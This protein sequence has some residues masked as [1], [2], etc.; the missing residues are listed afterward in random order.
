MST[1]LLERDRLKNTSEEIM[2]RFTFGDQ[3][4]LG[5]LQVNSVFDL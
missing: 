1:T 3:V 4:K 2:N 5:S